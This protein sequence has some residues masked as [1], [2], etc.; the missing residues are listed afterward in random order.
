MDRTVPPVRMCTPAPPAWVR[1]WALSSPHAFARQK[2]QPIKVKKVPHRFI[3]TS[4]GNPHSGPSSG[5][6]P[7]ISV[8]SNPNGATGN[9]AHW[10][11]FYTA[12]KSAKAADPHLEGSAVHFWKDF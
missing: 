5:S 6:C 11:P 2:Y 8:I 10:E 1:V 3:S 7:A 4:M 12:G 9:H